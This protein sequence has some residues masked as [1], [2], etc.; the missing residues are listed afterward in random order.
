MIRLHDTA[1]GEVLP[2]SPR[3]PGK[4]SM[5]VCGPTVYGP[6]HLGH[7]RFSLVF[8]VLRRYLEWS[9]ND[10]VYVSNITD[11]D[12]NILR[13]AEQEGRPWQEITE[14]C[15]A[16]WWRAMDAIGVRRPDHTP[17][18]TEYVEQMVAFVEDLVARDLAYVTSDGVYLSVADVDGYGLLAHQSLDDML[19]GGGERAIVGE[20]EKRNP[21]DFVLWKFAKPGEPAWPAPWGDGRPGWHT[22]CVVMSLDLLGEG[23][24]VHGGGMDLAFP[25]HEN[26]RAQAVAMGKD[27]ARRWVHNGFVEVGGEKMSKSLGNFTNLLDLIDE[28]DARAY[29]LLVL[30][31]HYRSPVEV[32]ASTVTEAESALARLDALA[33]RVADLPDAEPDADVL[34]EFSAA[35]DDDLGTPQAMA[36]VFGLVTRINTLLDAGEA[37]AAAPLAAAWFS[38]LGAM[39]LV[40]QDAAG[41]EVP[42]DVA[43]LAAA[44]DRA[45]ADKDWGTADALRDELVGLGWVVEDSAAGTVVR[46]G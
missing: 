16:V 26:E 23:F 22:E 11:I 10:V 19:A 17:H 1:A 13:R 34:A 28:H 44:R 24:D 30:Q 8:D 31:A 27:F 39:G 25:H 14:R 32:T 3:E 5:Y 21:A 41:D 36:L 4:V 37:D 7:G 20:S 9:G 40:P 46:K 43:A 35:M 12:D 45:R 15:E 2:L 6:P 29:R 42:D 38:V 18:A 33:R